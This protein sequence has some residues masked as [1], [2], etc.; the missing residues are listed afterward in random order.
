MAPLL[1]PDEC[2]ILIID[3]V[4]RNLERGHADCACQQALISRHS[5][6]HQ[7]AKIVDVPKFFA[8][9]SDPDDVRDWI[10]Q[11]SEH[12]KHHI[13]SINSSGAFWS[14]GGLGMVLA[15]EGRASLILCGFWLERNITFAALNALADG[16]DV[17]VLMD[18]CPTCEDHTKDAA[19]QRLLQAGIVPL[20]ITQ[21]VR[22]WAEG[23]IDESRRSLLRDLLVEK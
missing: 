4:L 17:F 3:A 6:L 8:I 5:L 22:E 14:S 2:S 1:E 9:D 21:M 16:F 12:H 11:P 7:A 10:A 19:T 18:A 13:Y 20:T 15:A 23:A